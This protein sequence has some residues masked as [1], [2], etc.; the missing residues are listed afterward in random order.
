MCQPRQLPQRGFTAHAFQ[1]VG[2]DHHQIWLTGNNPFLRHG[3]IVVKA[4]HRVLQT[5]E[6]NRAVRRRLLP[7]HQRPG[8]A[9]AEDKQHALVQ[10]ARRDFRHI[11]MQRFTQRLALCLLAQRVGNHLDF[12]VHRR[13]IVAARH[14]HHL[15]LA[16]F[17]LLQHQRRLRLTAGQHQRRAQGENTFRIELAQIADVRQRL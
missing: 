12:V 9:V 5:R 17:H 15:H 16:A 8:A 11:V 7:G 10:R 6:P 2:G 13:R 14:I 3:A 4:L 1:A